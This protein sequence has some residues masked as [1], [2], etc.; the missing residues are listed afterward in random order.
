MDGKTIQVGLAGCGVSG[1]IFHALFISADLRFTLK[2]VY[3]RTSDKLKQ[4]Y[5]ISIY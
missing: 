1:Q 2:K 5:P 4:A 3:E